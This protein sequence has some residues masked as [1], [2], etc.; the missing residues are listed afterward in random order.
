MAFI[1]LDG[2]SEELTAA[3]SSSALVLPITNGASLC[4][5]LGA[6]TSKLKIS[7]G[8]YEEMV[9]VTGCS[10]GN[11]VVTRAQEGT[12]ARAFAAG[13][14]VAYVIT[15]ATICALINSGECDDIPGCTPLT[16]VAGSDFPAAET[17]LPYAHAIAWTGT[18]SATVTVLAKP[19]WMTVTPVGV[20]A[21]SSVVLTGTPG[22]STDGDI[23]QLAITNCGGKYET[24]QRLAYCT[25][26]GAVV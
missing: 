12:A 3:V 26:A 14:C 9:L 1:G 2:I 8:V 6:G 17:G 4:A 15:T 11:P 24:N 20:T 7:D 13:S 21:G 22:V 25:P 23:V 16:V 19:S 18:A 10:S 5:R